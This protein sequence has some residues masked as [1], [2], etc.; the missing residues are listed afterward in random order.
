MAV[1]LRRNLGEALTY[2][3]LDDNFVDY[4][5]FR[6][7]FEQSHWIGS[8]DGKFVFYNNATGKLELKSNAVT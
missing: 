2:D 5:T 8:N 1:V 4:T 6:D 3:Q 7:K